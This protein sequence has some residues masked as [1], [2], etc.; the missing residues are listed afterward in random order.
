MTAIKLATLTL[1][2]RS[3]TRKEGHKIVSDVEVHWGKLIVARASLGGRYTPEQVL[4]EFRK[5]PNRFKRGAS[6]DLA[7]E[8][9]LVA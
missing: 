9:G 7:K 1:S 4:A 2:A 6:Y 5:A 8:A 3:Y